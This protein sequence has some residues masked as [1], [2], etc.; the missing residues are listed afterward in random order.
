MPLADEVIGGTVELLE[1]S[2]TVRFANE[3]VAR[4]ETVIRVRDSG[5]REL[6]NGKVDWPHMAPAQR[7]EFLDTLNEPPWAAS[8][9]VEP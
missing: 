1:A 4:P 5:L 9:G 7:R 8:R 2:G 6:F 3:P